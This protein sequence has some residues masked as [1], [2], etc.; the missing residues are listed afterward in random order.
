MIAKLLQELWQTTMKP[1]YILQ[2][3]INTVFIFTKHNFQNQYLIKLIQNNTN[4]LETECYIQR[5]QQRSRCCFSSSQCNALHFE[6]NNNIAGIAIEKH[7][8][9]VT[10]TDANIN[11]L[12]EMK[13]C[14]S[15]NQVILNWCTTLCAQCVMH[16]HQRANV[17]QIFL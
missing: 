6:K 10:S 2:V 13:V 3:F 14:H 9:S 15:Q 1:R 16:A 7:Q 4:W 17:S 12:Q 8:Y 11:I 5:N